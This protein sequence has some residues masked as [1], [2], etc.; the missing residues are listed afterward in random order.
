MSDIKGYIIDSPKVYIQNTNGNVQIVKATAGSITIDGQS[1][2]INAGWNPYPSA[3]IDTSKSIEI[4]V[5][6]ALLDFNSAAM[7][8]GG[9][10]KTEASEFYY[11]GV[12]YTVSSTTHSIT[13]PYV[14]VA[15]SI[16]ITGYTE[17]T[18]TPTSSQ[19]RTQIGATDTEIVFSTEA[20]NKVVY[21]VFKVATSATSEV[22]T[23]NTDSFPKSALC[24]YQEPVYEDDDLESD[25]VGWLQITI[26]KAKIQPRFNISSSYKS[27][28]TFEMTLRGLDPQR[29]DGKMF[30]MVFMPKG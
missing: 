28:S 13:L 9:E 15:Q 11:F 29:T 17:T 7:A 21:P 12:P 3:I 24:I 16:K 2:D 30:E 20:D 25:I 14:A 4:S 8:T 10:Q 6:N 23:V 5:T 19:F 26:Y 22:I 18:A 1:I 27:T